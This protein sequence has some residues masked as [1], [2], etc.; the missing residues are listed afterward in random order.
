MADTP[1]EAKIAV[2]LDFENVALG[3]KQARYDKFRVNL[4]LERLLE[5]GRIIF[6]R[7]YADWHRYREYKNELHEAAI[8][9]VDIPIKG[10]GGKNSA[11]IRM[12]VDAMDL[13]YSKEHI[14]IFALVTGDSD[15]SPLVQ[16]LAEN[17]KH[18]IGIGVKS[19]TSE[20]LTSICDE[21]IYY[22]DLVRE[23]KRGAQMAGLPAKKGECF[24]LLVD[25]TQALQRENHEVIWGS[26]VKQQI[27]RKK[28][29]FNESYYGYRTFSRLLEDAQKHKVVRLRR[30]EKSGGYIIT[31]LVAA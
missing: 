8:E 20:L 30:D 18:I 1:A 22:E 9:L 17:D 23:S 25:A 11:D 6:K 21:F 5:K 13:C 4:V 31:E 27:K 2:F 19:S 15:F 3:A 28:P 7:A 29:S 16:K 10:I 14:N 26:M 12:V 24:Q